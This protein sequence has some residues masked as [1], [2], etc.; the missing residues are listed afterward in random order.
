MTDARYEDGEEGPLHLVARE[1][2][3]VTVISALLQDAVFPG[4][5]MR[6]DKRRR[7]FVALL[8]RFRWEDSPAAARTGR[9]FERVR[10]VL[11]IEDVQKVRSMGIAPGDANQVLSLLSIGWR[12]GAEGSGVLTLILAG[13]G[14]VELEVEALELR[15]DDVTKPYVAPS[16]KAPQHGEDGPL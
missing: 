5:E 15:L 12:P 8:N 16:R 11:T 1:A 3:D 6:F 13:D 7:R 2:E 14:L 9:A 4:S 10:S